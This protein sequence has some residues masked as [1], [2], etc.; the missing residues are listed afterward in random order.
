LSD[1]KE[2]KIGNCCGPVQAES[3]ERGSEKPEGILEGC[4]CNKIED[5][6]VSHWEGKIDKVEDQDHV[7]AVIFRVLFEESGQKD[8][9]GNDN[10]ETGDPS[11][12]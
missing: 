3:V 2:D 10:E 4:I 9:W 1:N 7:K 11:L 12:T 5:N 6:E 8:D